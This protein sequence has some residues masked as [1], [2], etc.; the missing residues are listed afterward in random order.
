MEFIGQLLQFATSPLGLFVLVVGG[1]WVF[2]TK[3]QGSVLPWLLLAAFG[4]AASLAEFRDEYIQ[5]A[6]DLVFPLEQLRQ[7][8]R[9]LTIALLALLLALAWRTPDTWR[10]NH[11]PRPLWCLFLLQGVFLLK[12][13]YSGD[14]LFVLLSAVTYCGLVAM[15]VRGPSRWLQSDQ[16]FAWGLGSIALV[17]AIFLGANLYQAQFDLYPI[18]FVH[19]LFLGT[20]GNPQHA[21]VLLM[22]TLP[23]WYFFL[24]QPQAFWQRS[25]WGSA[26]LITLYALVQTGSRTGVLGAVVG[27]VVF[28]GQRLKLWQ[29]VVVFMLVGS[30]ALW[31][32]P[33]SSPT[34]A[35]LPGLVG[36]VVPE[37]FVRM[38]NTRAQIW[39]AQWN[40]FMAYPL[41][42]AP[43]RGDR[44]GFGE[45]SWL[46]AAASAGVVGLVPLALFAYYCLGMIVRLYRI[47]YHPNYRLYCSAVTAGLSSLLIG[48]VGEAYLLGLISFPLLA[49]GMYLV[50]GQYLLDCWQRD[51]HWQP[52]AYDFPLSLPQQPLR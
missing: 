52:A 11:F 49:L 48:S 5:D 17:G 51:R 31:S 23:A 41:L 43:L 47:G 20:T 7:A 25:I 2:T 30:I 15:V 12:G 28:F 13:L 3:P 45:N 14:L 38:E 6:P 50:L 24:M 8:G 29:M 32:A 39:Q 35:E 34:T 9:P 10:K 26:I 21:A 42:G 27:L 44:L 37:K 16:D 19:N 4:F 46:A 36:G 18:T 1:L 22:L 40:T 33:G